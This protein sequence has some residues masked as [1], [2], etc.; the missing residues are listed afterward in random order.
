MKRGEGD[1]WYKHLPPTNALPS[2][3]TDTPVRWKEQS[4]VTLPR[5]SSV[6]FNKMTQVL[7]ASCFSFVVL[8]LEQVILQVPS[9][10]AF[11][12]SINM[13]CQWPGFAL[14]I[15]PQRGRYAWGAELTT[16]SNSKKHH[17]QI[18]QFYCSNF[19]HVCQ[20]FN[21]FNDLQV[22]YVHIGTH[23]YACIIYDHICTI[24][25]MV[26]LKRFHCLIS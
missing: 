22:T 17:I 8:G 6:I 7:W 26:L 25:V 10:P 14:M 3:L 16:G 23:I 20:C 18:S 1:H 19:C 24:G 4:L 13:S 2:H 12:H 5:S 9:H 15:R 11:S 21:K